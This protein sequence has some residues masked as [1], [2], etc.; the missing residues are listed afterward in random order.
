MPPPPDPPRPNR[1][2]SI[3]DWYA[4]RPPRA[5]PVRPPGAARFPLRRCSAMRYSGD[6]RLLEVLLVDERRAR[7]R[8]RRRGRPELGVPDR[9]ERRG[10]RSAGAR[11]GRRFLV[12]VLVLAGS[13][14]AARGSAAVDRRRRHAPARRRRPR[15]GHPRR[16][17]GHDHD[18]DRHG[19]VGDAARRRPR[20]GPR[21][22]RPR[23]PRHRSRH[24]RGR[25]A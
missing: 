8:G 5:P 23:L 21:R 1:S 14:A 17:R 6:L 20:D 18:R 25:R 3:A 24:R 13:A 11:D 16:D 4:D 19:G 7:C 12:L 10:A 22:P 15:A 9:S 2:R